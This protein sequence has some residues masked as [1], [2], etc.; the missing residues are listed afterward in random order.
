M[1][2]TQKEIYVL[3]LKIYYNYQKFKKYC[4]FYEYKD[5]SIVSRMPMSKK[6]NLEYYVL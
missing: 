3:K 6:N 4:Y 1:E 2:F 5:I